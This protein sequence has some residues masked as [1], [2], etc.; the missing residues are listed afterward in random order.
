M[1]EG[2]RLIEDAPAVEDYLALRELSGLSPKT[3]EQAA[4]G[5]ARQT[6]SPG[7]CAGPRRLRAP[8][9]GAGT[10]PGRSPGGA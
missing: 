1:R 9:R 7:P 2:Y 3:R 8:G 10:G 4:A 5:A 6:A